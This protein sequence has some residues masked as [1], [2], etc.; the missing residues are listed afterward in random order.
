MTL[1][2]ALEPAALRKVL[3]AGLRQGVADGAL[4]LLMVEA[5][6]WAED[7]ACCDELLALLR[8]RGWLVRHGET[9]KTRLG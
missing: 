3:K 5:F 7:P 9:W 8:D 4:R 1:L 2:L 6:G